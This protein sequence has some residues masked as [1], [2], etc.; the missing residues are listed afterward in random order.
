M[1]KT[2]LLT[3][4][5]ILQIA[6]LYAQENV[7]VN[8]KEFKTDK[9]GF[10]AAWNHV[11][12]G[13]SF[14]SK[15]GIWYTRALEEYKLAYSYNKLNA[16]LNY[17]IGVS[18]LFS[19]NKEEAA[20][21][22]R[23]AYSLDSSVAGDVL[24]LTGRALIYKAKFLEA[25]EKINLWLTTSSKKSESDI[26]FAKR[27]LTECKTGVS[28]TKDTVRV[29]I[30][31]LGGNINSDADDYSVVLSSDGKKMFFATR[32][33]LRPKES[34]HYRDTKFNENI[35]V[36]ENSVGKW[37]VAMPAG[38]NL[39]TDFCETPLYLDKSGSLLYI[40]TGYE[41]GGDIM[42]SEFRKGE[43]RAPEKEKFGISSSGAETSIAF[44]PDGKEIAFISDRGKKG[45]GGKDIYFIHN[46]GRKWSKPVIADSLNSEYDEESVCYSRGGD[47]LW[48]SSMGHNTLGGFDIFYSVRNPNG[49]WGNPVN[50]GY[51]VNTA[52]DDMF[53]VPSPVNDSLFYF[54]SDRGSGI[55]GLD[56]YMGKLLPAVKHILKTPAKHDTIAVKDTSAVLKKT[57]PVTTKPDT[58][59]AVKRDSIPVKDTTA[60]VIKQP[61]VINII[62]QKSKNFLN[63]TEGIHG[64]ELLSENTFARDP[65]DYEKLLNCS[66]L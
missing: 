45:A 57:L 30:T 20:D 41:G 43:W 14:Y 35:F 33:S 39:I 24:L 51:P 25:E 50:A 16:G 23:S 29:E 59:P 13:N 22:F 26:K 5:L 49:G 37:S 66:E 46:K 58:L 48:F 44:S 54:S 15:G 1:K 10:D 3:V 31:N 64:A 34:S 36:S 32:R 12:D 21:Y 42:F 38:K 65:Y 53:Y 19:D 28:I 63:F 4:V 60:V 47:T 11:K 40:Y 2:Y 52:W 61:M 9:P 17:R 6:I 55:G 7:S 62:Q 18:A 27:L 8:R 56:I